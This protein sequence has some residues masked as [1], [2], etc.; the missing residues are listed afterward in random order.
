MIFVLL[1]TSEHYF[2]TFCVIF[3]NKIKIV[4]LLVKHITISVKVNQYI[5]S[6][7]N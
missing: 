4:Q 2:Y 5:Y 6:D 3:L 7:K 1:E